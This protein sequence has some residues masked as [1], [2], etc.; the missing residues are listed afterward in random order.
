M[1]T[2]DF[3]TH[4]EKRDYRRVPYTLRMIRFYGRK[5]GMNPFFLRAVGTFATFSA[6]AMQW[7]N[8]LHDNDPFV[9]VGNIALFGGGISF[10]FLA[11]VAANI[12][13]NRWK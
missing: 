11:Y 2:Y 5:G 9:T 7:Y 4:S 10:F 6:C 13:T 8:R 3:R 1:P 12:P